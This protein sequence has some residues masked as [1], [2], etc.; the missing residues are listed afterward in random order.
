MLRRAREALASRPPP[1]ATHSAGATGQY[2]GKPRYRKVGDSAWTVQFDGASPLLPRGGRRRRRWSREAERGAWAWR[3]MRRPLLDR[4]APRRAAGRPYPCVASPC[5]ALPLHRRSVSLYAYAY[6]AAHIPAPIR[7]TYNMVWRVCTCTTAV[8]ASSTAAV[9][10][11]GCTIAVWDGCAASSAVLGSML[12]VQSPPVHPS[13]RLYA[14]ST[15]TAV[16]QL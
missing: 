8:L 3:A 15:A 16:L 6:G 10:G 13:V 11:G 14:R 12:R 9:W 5:A 1:L 4:C 2:Q 7:C